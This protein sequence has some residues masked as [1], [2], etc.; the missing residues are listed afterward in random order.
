[1]S[2]LRRGWTAFVPAVVI[3]FFVWLV[4]LGHGLLGLG[5][6]AVLAGLLW[7]TLFVLAAG[8]E[9]ARRPPEDSGSTEQ[10]AETQAFLELGGA[11]MVASEAAELF[12]GRERWVH[13]RVEKIAFLDPNVVRRRISVDLEIPGAGTEEAKEATKWLP[14]SVLRNWPPVLSFDLCDEANRTLPLI[15]KLSTNAL[16]EKIL[17]GVVEGALGQV[18]PSLNKHLK[19]L[20]HGEGGRARDSFTAVRTS[21]EEWSAEG[22]EIDQENLDRVVDLAGILVD[23]TLLWVSVKGTPGE[24]R[25]LKLAYDEPTRKRLSPIRDVLTAIGLLSLAVDFDVPHIGDSGS[26][27]LD[28]GAP[29]GLE[30]VAGDLLLPSD[31]EVALA[32]KG[33]LHRRLSKAIAL[34]A[35][36][37]GRMLS[38]SE[39]PQLVQPERRNVQ[40]LAQRAHIYV[41]GKRPRSEA[42]AYIRFLPQR[43]GTITTCFLV[44]L[45]AA[46]TL[47]GFLAFAPELLDSKKS[48][49]VLGAAVAFLLLVP[50]LL[51]YVLL[52]PAG[53]HPFV[54]KVLAGSRALAG[55]CLL[56]PVGD[57]ALLLVA[58]AG[59][60]DVLG[61]RRE[62]SWAG[63]ALAAHAAVAWIIPRRGRRRRD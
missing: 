39:E 37:W 20:V 22:N 18:P 51:G 41:S 32:G 13:R 7:L 44:T 50:G 47:D 5:G 63:W 17:F 11:E 45:L 35:R 2:F 53:E 52:H 28:V 57:A 16:D 49:G 9:L 21:L 48:P 15:T 6:A 27:H 61:W 42:G 31:R 54:T 12:W 38:R 26:Y 46:A 36:G 56:L 10:A 62:L 1:V 23:R 4:F 33:R 29:D 25:I 34:A 14:L 60:P 58:S 43:S 8:W 55:L 19:A 3:A 40:L 59:H 24:R 30:V